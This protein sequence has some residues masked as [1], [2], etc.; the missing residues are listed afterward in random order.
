M[1]ILGKN[2]DVTSNQMNTTDSNNEEFLLAKTM[3]KIDLKI[4]YLK[5]L[6]TVKIL[7]IQIV[8]MN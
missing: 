4:M 1:I 6:M 3:K 7:Q 8:I 5:I 2:P